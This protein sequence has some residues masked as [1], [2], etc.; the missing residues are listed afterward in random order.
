MSDH[1][2]QAL[3]DALRDHIAHLGDPGA[4]IVG[5]S[6]VVEVITPDSDGPWLK[7]L[8][9][10]DSTPWAQVGRVAALQQIV[11]SSLEAGW[12]PDEGDH[13]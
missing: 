2:D 12:M 5:Y 4:V 11:A 13:E 9:D 8:G 3:R 10:S 7:T 6:A 1:T